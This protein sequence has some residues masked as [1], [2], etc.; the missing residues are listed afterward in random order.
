M[1]PGTGHA[2]NKSAAAQ[3]LSQVGGQGNFGAAQT[4][5]PD[6]AGDVGNHHLIP[7]LTREEAATALD[8]GDDR[9]SVRGTPPGP[10]EAVRCGRC[11]A[12]G[13]AG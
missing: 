5:R 12:T 2:V 1:E 3:A 8:G 4:S 11:P 7:A 9:L 10:Q 6:R 13:P